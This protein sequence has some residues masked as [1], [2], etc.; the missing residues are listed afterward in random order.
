MPGK[1]KLL[2]VAREVTPGKY[3]DGDG[4]YLVVA[5]PTSRNWSYRY[6]FKGKERWHGPR[7]TAGCFPQGRADQ[8][9]CGP[10]ATPRRRRGLR[11]APFSRN[12]CLICRHYSLGN[13]GSRSSYREQRTGNGLS[14]LT[15]P[16]G[17]FFCLCGAR[18]LFDAVFQDDA[19]GRDRRNRRDKSGGPS[20]L[21]AS[22]KVKRN[23]AH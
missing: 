22:L 23:C 7:L 2:D 19:F 3:S 21:E 13:R 9:R 12:A 4:L 1:L 6:W 5:G 15:Q 18:Q 14:P 10:A 17:F 8:A 20:L 11:S 16:G